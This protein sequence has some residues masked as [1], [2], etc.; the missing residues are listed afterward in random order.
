MTSTD[1][2]LFQVEVLEDIERV[3][4]IIRADSNAVH[5][6]DG[7]LQPLHVAAQLANSDVVRLLIAAGA[8][9][10]A[11][12]QV[13][14]ATPLLYACT[15]SNDYNIEVEEGDVTPNIEVLVAA[16]ADVH[17]TDSDSWNCLH[18]AATAR[19]PNL[20]RYLIELGVDIEA[21][22]E[23]VD[24]PVFY[25][26]RGGLDDV[27]RAFKD[28]GADL[29]IRDE[30]GNT[31]LHMVCQP[32]CDDDEAAITRQ[33]IEAGLEVDAVN[34]DGCTPLSLACEAGH[35]DRVRVLVDAGA[36]IHTRDRVGG[37]LLHQASKAPAP[38]PEVLAYLLEAHSLEPDGMDADGR[39]PLSLASQAGC[40]ASIER[41]LTAGADVCLSDRQGLTPFDYAKDDEVIA[42]LKAHRMEASLSGAR[43]MPTSGL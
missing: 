38:A 1:N 29:Y 43:P 5:E 20:C 24:T 26:V 27:F 18:A 14:D 13:L 23:K 8:N 33:L 32:G 16:G 10:E 39:T 25:A 36:D 28:A 19:Q 41:L 35:M 40:I 11:R 4:S 6:W 31:L 30:E 21:C 37:T 42:L 17:V 34:W 22:D 3:R 15:C 2:N 12:E 7:G 9:I